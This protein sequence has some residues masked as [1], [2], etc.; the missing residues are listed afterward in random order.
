MA[1]LIACI[2]AYNEED[3][4]PQCLESIK[5][6]VDEIILVDGRIAAFP[7]VGASS[8]D[9]TIEI[10]RSYGARVIAS[11]QPYENEAAMRSR[12]L[13]GKEGDW[14]LLIDADEKC[15]T[16]LPSV[17]DFP[18]GIGTYAIHTRMIGAPT[19]VWRP[20][21]FRHHG[22]MEYREIHDA[23]FSNETLISRPKDAPRLYSVWFAHYQMAR[24]KNR[25]N[26]KRLYYQTGY[27]HEPQYRKE[28]RMFNYG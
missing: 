9:N 6:K 7:G 20:R 5:G 10:A 2:I 8:T 26:Q 28:W 19:N 14:Y 15:M 11:A 21:L 1:K 13:V 25:R 23:L 22:K 24:S 18:P 12:Y 17:A 16:D 4:L 3:L 27:T